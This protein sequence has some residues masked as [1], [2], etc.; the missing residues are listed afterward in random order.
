[1][2]S[3]K[4]LL[5][6]F[7]ICWFASDLSAQLR[8]RYFY[9]GVAL[10]ATNYKGDLDDNFTLKFTKLGLGGIAGYKF[11]PHMSVRLGFSQG[12]MGASD[13]KAARDIPR[14]RRNLSFRSP[15]TEGSLVF[16]YEFFANNRKYQYRPQF[17]PYIFGGVGIFAFNPQGK[18]GD[19]W[20][21][22]QPLG[23]E[24]QNLGNQCGYEDCPDPYALVDV[25]IPFGAGIRYRLTDKID[26]NLEVGLRKTFTDYL[27]D[28]SGQYADYE[29]LYAQNPNAALLS[30]RIDRSVYPQGGRFWNG[31]RGDNTQMDWY[32]ISVVS[33]TYI[34]DWV[35]C[36]KFR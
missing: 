2:K 32:V 4:Y 13:A 33:A 23:T 31:I 15:L 26:L 17:S 19:E 24:G 18:L 14:R 30:D 27:D 11:H 8:T 21:D 29:A 10:G 12:W 3:I 34:L 36:P 22:L 7:A 6:F 5:V 28:V 25:S 16:V 20:F 35:K 1:M 9:A